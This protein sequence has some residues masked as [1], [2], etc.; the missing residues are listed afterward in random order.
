MAS[1]IVHLAAGYL[2]Y[3]LLSRLGYT[4]ELASRT[5]RCCLLG[6]CLFAAML[7]DIDSVVGILAGDLGKYHNQF[8]HSL[9][10]GSVVTF[11]AGMALWICRYNR[12]WHAALFV[13]ASYWV[14]LGL[15]WFTHGRGVKLFWPFLED[16]FLSPVIIF[17]GVK[18]SDGLLSSRHWITA[19]NE[20]GVI[21]VIWIVYLAV[22]RFRPAG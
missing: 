7:P 16:R 11:V 6:T 15:D 18:W 8:T 14:H 22:R 5:G 12:P 17:F 20:V 4:R 3:R 1:P 2:G 19:A 21:L 9:F 13:L 10:F